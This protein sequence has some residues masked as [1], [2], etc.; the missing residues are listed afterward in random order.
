METHFIGKKH[1]L[2]ELSYRNAV[3]TDFKSVVGGRKMPDA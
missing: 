3:H 2:Q 1:Q